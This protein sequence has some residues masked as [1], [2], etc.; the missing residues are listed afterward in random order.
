[1]PSHCPTARTLCALTVVASPLVPALAPAVFAILLATI[2]LGGCVKKDYPAGG[3]VLS[4][5]EIETSDG[6]HAYPGIDLSDLSEQLATAKS[7]KFLG[8][9]EGVAF[10][11]EIY[12]R[13]VLARDLAR[14]E[15]YCRAR[16]YYEAKVVAGRV[17]RIDEHHVRVL[18][19]VAPGQP[20]VTTTVT[21]PG[22]E[23]LP[24]D[25]AFDAKRAVALC[26]DGPC[27][28]T[29]RFD[30]QRY[31]SSRA[32]IVRVL[33]DH[34]YAFAEVKSSAV[35]DLARHSASATYAINPGPSATF[36][37]ITVKGLD[38]IPEK[39]VRNAL[40][41]RRGQPYSR[42]EI[43][44][45]RAAL[46]AL[47]VF[48]TV[49]IQEDRSSPDTRAVPLSVVV[50][51]SSLRT[52][53]AGIGASIDQLEITNTLRLG[54]E[55]R[56]FLGGMRRFQIDTRPGITYFPT[57]L[58]RIE[59]PTRFFPHNRLRL[60]LRQP[61]FLEGR[62]TGFI[63]GEYNI[64][65]L[66]FPMAPDA[67]PEDEFVIGYNELK[68][69]SGL[70]R[71]FFGQRMVI[72]PSYNWQVNYPFVYKT[73]ANQSRTP[74]GF[75]PIVISYPELAGALD[76][77]DDPIN[78]SRGLFVSNSFQVAGYIFRGDVSDVRIR[79]EIRTYLPISKK[80]ILATKTTF[81]FLFPS[82]YGDTLRDTVNGVPIVIATP[83]DARVVSDQHKLLFRA[84][85]SGGPNSNRGYGFREVGPHG[86][87]GFLLQGGDVNCFDPASDAER[88]QCVRPLGGVL[89]WEASLEI[90]FPI[91]G[92]L[93][94]VTFV[95]ASHV[96][97]SMRWRFDAPHLS[98]GAG[99]RYET[100][101]GPVRLDIGWRLVEHV[102]SPPSADQL[103]DE[104]VTGPLFGI[105][106]VAV[107]I[108]LGDAF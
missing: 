59:T 98:P 86:P 66:I 6:D 15:R 77:R 48:S 68:A 61:A 67:I 43:E 79:P 99:V 1:M 78:P 53:R 45:A 5:V 42:A 54:W 58:S 38:E 108:A 17:I 34:G 72:T 52:V 23:N 9:W 92:P 10:D 93:G 20:V 60:E 88:A 50:R 65:P 41:L 55:S 31:E 73:T 11:Y 89:L 74:D 19:S 39:L 105:A 21:V 47:G 44:E 69:S 35:V 95:D 3:S 49:D 107:H 22:L 63:A 25:V 97:R 26:S 71:A 82:N 32:A 102:G 40:Q 76:F 16:G 51:E 94:A 28:D 96:N 81:G 29:D 100:P 62:T 87:V 27:G 57:R 18:V 56:N 64:Y 84:F 2:A 12:D 7:P 75:N 101:V 8:L 85:Y 103:Q 90:R 14:V 37:R 33:Q 80:V 4:S 106:P 83:R 91:S 24:F 30:E 13:N 70:Q 36:G 46:V 104:A